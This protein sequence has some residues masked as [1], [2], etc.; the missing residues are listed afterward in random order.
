MALTVYPDRSFVLTIEGGG[1]AAGD[2]GKAFS[3]L[4]ALARGLD[5]LVLPAPP[6]K[7]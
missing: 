6:K 3:L 7:P 1:H 2:E 4:D 5:Y